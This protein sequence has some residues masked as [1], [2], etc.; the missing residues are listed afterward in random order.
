[1][2]Y[3]II[4]KTNVCFQYFFGRYNQIFK[5][6]WVAG[7]FKGATTPTSLLPN[8]QEHYENHKSWMKFIEN[9]KAPIGGIVFTGWS[10][11][12]HFS[13]LC[14][15][16]PVSIPSLLLSLN[17]VKLY[18]KADELIYDRWSASILCPSQ[19]N[20]QS[21]AY[22]PKILS[23]C[24]FEGSDLYSTILHY[25]YIRTNIET[26]YKTF[27]ETRGWF[28]SYNIRHNFTSP[29]RLIE[30]HSLYTCHQFLERL[31]RFKNDTREVMNQYYDKFTIEEWLEQKVG[32]LEQKLNDLLK[33]IDSLM[34]TKVW[35]RRPIR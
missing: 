26:F 2:F 15:L 23:Y 5:R 12:D 22:D 35:P 28:T 9:S 6:I 4:M 27:S 1:M 17:S 20:P 18:G 25:E 30:D 10:R 8:L 33:L 13:V 19:I 24:R 3:P 34:K 32:P 31:E 11:Y 14:E 7:A 29:F 16:L 21:I